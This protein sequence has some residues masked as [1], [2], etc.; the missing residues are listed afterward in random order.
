MR[1]EILW[2]MKFF[3]ATCH[4]TFWNPL[5]DPTTYN[6]TVL[7]TL[8]IGLYQHLHYLKADQQP[9]FF[10]NHTG[11]QPVISVF[12]MN[13]VHPVTA[14]KTHTKKTRYTHVTAPITQISRRIYQIRT[15]VKIDSYLITNL[16]TKT[17]SQAAFVSR[18]SYIRSNRTNTQSS[19][20]IALCQN[21]EK[22][23]N[24]ENIHAVYNKPA[25][26]LFIF[27]M[28]ACGVEPCLQWSIFILK[29]V[30]HSLDK[31]TEIYLY[32]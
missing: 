26:T 16:L 20:N 15:T 11:W 1:D 28:V 9:F 12:K 4:L 17:P 31:R 30:V 22:Q 23:P 19:Y 7:I 18:M 8:Q 14:L 27:L 6:Y 3:G 29:K 2:W 24:A 25:W 10:L 5:Y 32:H 21:A 13:G